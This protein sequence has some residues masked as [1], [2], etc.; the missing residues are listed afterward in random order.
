[1]APPPDL[2]LLLT[3]L[4][5]PGQS[6]AEGEVIRDW[7]KAEGATYDRVQFHV[8][9]GKGG[10]VLPG[11]D[12]AVVRGWETW[13]RKKIDA[14]AWQN[15][16]VVIVEAKI[17]LNLGVRGQLEGYAMLWR[18]QYPAIPVA[19][20]LAIA[21]RADGD[22]IA[23]L[24]AGGIRVELYEDLQ[25]AGATAETTAGDAEPPNGGPVE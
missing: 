13:T 6:A 15:G 3:T 24:T 10:D 18:E 11:I 20:L 9:V 1:M 7:L 17:K 19:G 2:D 8:L 22:V 4:A 5:Y 14:L 25:A 12:P 16:A 21:R 23:V